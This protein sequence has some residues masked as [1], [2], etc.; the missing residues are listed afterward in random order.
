[1]KKLLLLTFF[2]FSLSCA[3]AIQAH[4]QGMNSVS[5]SG[6]RLRGADGRSYDLASLR[7]NV[8]LLSFGATWCQPCREELKALEQL[9]KEYKDKPVRILW[10]SIE[11]EEEVSDGGL[12]DYAKKLKLT[13]PV[14]RDPDKT[15]FLRFSSRLRLPTILFFDK[16]GNLNAPNHVGM[17]AVPV[18]L[19]TMRGRLD[20][21]LAAG[22][23]MNSTG[24]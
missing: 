13:F 24:R 4:G 15:T 6:I 16:N 17:A 18:Y 9:K 8:V 12:R 10:V 5:A 22:A 7:G 23:G 19:S 2:C 11:T 3:L 1:M 20:K 14:L 21:L